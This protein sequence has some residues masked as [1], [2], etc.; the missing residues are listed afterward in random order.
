MTA[1]PGQPLELRISGHGLPGRRWSGR[2]GVHVGLQRGRDPECLVPGD[3]PQAEFTVPVRLVT[4]ADGAADF[5]GPHVQGRRGGR[6]VYLTWGEVGP[7]GGFAMFRRAKLLLGDI[8]GGQLREA[9][10]GGGALRARLALSA[11]DGSPRC[12]SV[13]P[14]DVRWSVEHPG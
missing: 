2:S 9:V 3:A 12:A 7:G 5:A 4:T 6:F 14:P 1:R 11:P 10:A 8:P 13:R